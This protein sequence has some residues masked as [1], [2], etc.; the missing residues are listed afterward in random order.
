MLKRIS[1]CSTVCVCAV[2]KKSIASG[3]EAMNIYERR[4][5]SSV[6]EVFVVFVIVFYIW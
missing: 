2:I 5:L 4:V 6:R 1:Q 3:G